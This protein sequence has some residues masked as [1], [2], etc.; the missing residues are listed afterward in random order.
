MQGLRLPCG[1]IK[2]IRM[3][4]KV[5][6][7]K[8][9]ALF[10]DRLNQ[11]LLDA[12]DYLQ[13]E[14]RVLQ[15]HLKK[16]CPKLVDAQRKVLAEKA[17]KLGKAIEKYANLVS[18]DTLYRWHRRLLAQKFDGS[19]GRTYPGRSRKPKEVE[20]LIV[21]IARE[22]PRSGSLDITNRMNN[23]GHS[24][25]KET[26]RQILERNGIDPAPERRKQT[27]WADFIARHKD[28]IWGC[29]FFTVEAWSGFH[30][31]TYYVLF[32]IHLESR[33][34]IFGGMTENPTG[35]WCEQQARE[36]TG[37]DGPIQGFRRRGYL[38]HDRG[39][40]FTRAFGKVFRSV[41]IRPLK[42]PARSPNL[43]AFAER[44]VRSIKHECLNHLILIG[45]DSVRR[46]IEQYLEHY[47]SER[48]HQGLD[49]MI[50]FPSPEHE[51]SVGGEG[52]VVK[53]SRLGGLLNYYHR[54]VA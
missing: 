46:A 7:A 50:P 11:E 34:V 51:Q 19:K 47:H 52:R 29:D 44:F 53:R 27:R 35:E 1:S 41:N 10:T 6:L 48:N 43:N 25:C 39:S 12:I 32:F 24:I 16:K 36:L 4:G 5:L 40:N 15:H 9:L 8:L 26:V 49:N 33:R 3:E 42:L 38:I 31:A 37:F 54:E 14:V 23:L 30:L 13:E 21:Q 18:P 28:V 22:N 2:L 20:D 17:K 45:E